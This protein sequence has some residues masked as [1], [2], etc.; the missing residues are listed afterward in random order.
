MGKLIQIYGNSSMERDVETVLEKIGKDFFNGNHEAFC[1]EE[2][3][4]YA[5]SLSRVDMVEE[6]VLWW[7]KYRK[8]HRTLVYVYISDTEEKGKERI[9]ITVYDLNKEFYNIVWDNFKKYLLLKDFDGTIST[10]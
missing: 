6:K 5:V 3:D 2:R 7:K 10:V 8:V 1:I 9:S 4:S